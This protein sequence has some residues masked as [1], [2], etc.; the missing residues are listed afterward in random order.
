MTYK[1]LSVVGEVG[2]ENGQERPRRT[3]PAGVNKGMNSGEREW[4]FVDENQGRYKVGI[5]PATF[6]QG[7]K[8]LRFNN[9]GLS[10]SRDRWK[11]TPV[12]DSGLLRSSFLYSLGWCF[13]GR[14]DCWFVANRL[15]LHRCRH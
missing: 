12:E 14:G 9:Y 11:V 6:G 4:V 3:S 8:L 7:G 2:M 5:A 13:L 10:L 1:Y 15:G